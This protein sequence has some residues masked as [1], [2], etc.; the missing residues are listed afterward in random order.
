MAAFTAEPASSTEPVPATSQHAFTLRPPST[1]P[2]HT[3]SAY[4]TSPPSIEWLDGTWHVTHSTLPMWT[5]ARNVQIKYTPIA[6]GSA[7]ASPVSL[8]DLVTYQGLDSDKIKSLHGLGKP[9]EGG[10]A[11]HWRGKGWLMIASSRWEVLGY[12]E[13]DSKNKWVVTYF[14][15]TMFTPAG[16]DLYSRDPGGL[17]KE[18]VEGIKK[19]LVGLGHEEVGKLANELF[20]IKMD[21]G[22]VGKE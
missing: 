17:A 9:E 6:Q 18:T 4:P 8:D 14:A 16:V 21:K 15:K 13:D 2:F 3:S 1:K 19:G 7:N 10:W 11:W 20:E 22:R 5:K 12:G